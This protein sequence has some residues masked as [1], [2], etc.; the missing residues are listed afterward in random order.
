[1]LSLGICSLS[2]TGEKTV[3]VTTAAIP[4]D[5]LVVSRRIVILKVVMIAVLL[6]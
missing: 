3:V 5:I 2:E 1:M 6:L 4:V